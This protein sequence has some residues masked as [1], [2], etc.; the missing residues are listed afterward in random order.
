MLML[1]FSLIIM[2]VSAQTRNDAS[3]PHHKVQGQNPVPP[4]APDP[5]NP[6]DAPPPPPPP[7]ALEPMDNM[8]GHLNL[9][10][11]TEDQNA[12]IKKLRLIQMGSMTPLKNQLRE[13][14]A[15]LET[16][17][18][19]MPVDLNAA[20]A[21]VDE[22]GK[23]HTAMLK[24]MIRHDQALRDLLTPDQQVIFDSRPKPFLRN[25]K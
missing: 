11:L 7:P 18:T 23:I 1:I 22:M 5:P 10:D 14:K 12:Q 17:L 2:N 13:K 25:S 6:P 9:P 24:A 19:T 15:R 4:S 8:P 20:D 3:V 21:I 16:I